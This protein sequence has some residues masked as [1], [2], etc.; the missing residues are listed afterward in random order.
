VSIEAVVQAQSD[1][2]EQAVLAIIEWYRK[3][4]EAHFPTGSGHVGVSQSEAA[5]PLQLH[6]N[7]DDRAAVKVLNAMIEKRMIVAALLTDWSYG[8]AK[9]RLLKK[10]PRRAPS[11]GRVR[12]YQPEATGRDVGRLL[13]QQEL[14]ERAVREIVHGVPKAA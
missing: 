5:S 12:I 1:P 6:H 4:R 10:L 11:K 13:R 14:L 7:L 8:H 9:V 2:K 3:E